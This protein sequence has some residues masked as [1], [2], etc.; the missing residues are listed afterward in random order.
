MLKLS[1]SIS[2]LNFLWRRTEPKISERLGNCEGISR[3]SWLEI[4]NDDFKLDF[5]ISL[6][7][8]RFFGYGYATLRHENVKLTRSFLFKTFTILSS[9]WWTKISKMKV[10]IILVTM[11][12]IE[13]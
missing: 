11:M 1:L 5:N 3:A 12:M 4:K 7:I 10:K 9:D 13:F 8:R 6:V 2:F